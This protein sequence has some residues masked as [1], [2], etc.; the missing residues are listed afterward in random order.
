MFGPTFALVIIT[1]EV[2]F[3][4]FVLM[5]MACMLNELGLVDLCPG[6]LKRLALFISHI[7][8]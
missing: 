8:H 4:K 2:T 3:V 7:T 6:A 1:L 5:R